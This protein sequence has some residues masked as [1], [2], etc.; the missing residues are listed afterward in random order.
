MKYKTIMIDPPWEIDMMPVLNRRPK[1]AERLPYKTMSIDEIKALPINDISEVGCHIWLWT[2]NKYLPV[3]FELLK[4]WGFTYLAPIHWI[5]PSGCGLWFVSRTQ[6]I[7]FGYKDKCYFN[8]EK[9]KPN[10]L[11]TK[12]PKRHSE[13]PKEIYKLVE[14]ISDEPRIEFFA[15]QRYDGWDWYGNELSNTIQKR[16][17]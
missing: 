1:T 2:T 7:L 11:F 6:T 9:C 5:K 15:R 4:H 14:S 10:V 12:L 3:G 8:K 17:S 16:L 13:K